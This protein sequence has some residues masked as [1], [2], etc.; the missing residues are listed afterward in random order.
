MR[1]IV[2]LLGI[3]FYAAAA[4]AQTLKILSAGALIK[5]FSQ[6]KSH[7]ESPGR[8]IEAL[9]VFSEVF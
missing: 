1:S 9:F 5:R 2:I 6:K 8:P 3:A 4:S 7:D